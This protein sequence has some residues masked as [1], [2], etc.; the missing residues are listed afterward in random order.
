MILLNTIRERLLDMIFP[1]RCISCGEREEGGAGLCIRC[2]SHAP[3]AEMEK[4][5]ETAQWIFSLYDY[6]H[7]PLKKALQ[8]FKYKGKKRLARIFADVLYGRILEELSELSVMENF[9]A[10]L[11][12]PIPLSKKRYRERGYNQAELLCRELVK[13]DGGESARERTLGRSDGDGQRKFLAK[14]FRG[15]S[16]SAFS[17]VAT[18]VLIKIKNTEHQAR[19]Q[20]RSVR[21]KNITDSFGIRNGEKIK[22]RNIILIDDITTTGATLKEAKK[23]LKQSGARKV[24]AFTVA[25]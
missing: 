13:L 9:R 17:A 22:N 23:L 2:L 8:F 14:N 19:I 5:R 7:P 24:I 12:I 11:L 10:P 6:R 20:D 1:V 3:E 18:D 21:L 4:G 15:E 16:V 25:H